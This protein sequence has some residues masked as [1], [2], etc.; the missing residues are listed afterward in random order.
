MYALT[1]AAVFVALML[2]MA[3]GT[4][5]L[6]LSQQSKEPSGIVLGRITVGGKP[7]PNV[8]V[9]LMPYESYPTN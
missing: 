8:T 7:A 4:M 5:A 1:R 2:N 3:V 9:M 6:P